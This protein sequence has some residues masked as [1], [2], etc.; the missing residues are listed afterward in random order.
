MPG[1][2][3]WHAWLSAL[4]QRNPPSA[5]AR[6][7][8]PLS[9][10]YG[11]LAR[12]HRGLYSSGLR[13]RHKAA[14]PVVVVGNLLAGG[15]GKTPAV[16]AMAQALQARGRV[17][18]VVSRGYGRAGTGVMLV[19]RTSPADLV[20]DEPLLIHLRT[21][22]AVAVGGD[23]V[24]AAARLCAARPDIDVI[25]ADDGLQ[26]HR[27]AR[28]VEVWVFDDRGVGNGLLLPAGPLRQRLPDS[29]PD[30][31]LV[32]YSGGRRSTPLP[33]HLGQ[34]RLHG[35]VALQDWWS[36]PTAQGEPLSAWRG[37]EVTAAA[38]LARPEAFFAMLEGHG[39]RLRRLP[40]PDHAS[41]ATLPW[42]AEA[43]DVVVTEKDAVKL[44]PERMAPTR[45]WVAR[46]DFELEPAFIAALSRMLPTRP[47]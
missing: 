42:P 45:V 22:A 7:L 44:R 6:L 41:F 38:G 23:R 24:A 33:G 12:A 27:L 30:G 29:V 28:D 18:G 36:D 3:G 16:I 32:L 21:G 37:R 11:W 4:W 2:S 8:Q 31:C 20:G 5:S 17:P 25:L 10:L 35:L 1:P 34:R 15:A 39:L 40:M 43:I 14:R 46:L 26:H 9:V 13:R 19:D 47:S